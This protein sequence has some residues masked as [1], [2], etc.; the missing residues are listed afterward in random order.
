MNKR[1]IASV[2][3]EETRV[4]LLE[5]DELME[6]SVERSESGHLV[7]NIYK[8]RVKN[9]LPGMQAAF[10]DIGRDKNA[11]LYMGDAGR[12]A[13]SQHLTI[14]QDV[15]VQI[16]KDPMG[17]KGPRATI[18]LTLPGRYIVLM[19]S[20][21]YIGISRRIESEPERERLRQIAEKIRPEGMGVI[22]R[23]VA[24]DKSQDDLMKDMAYLASMW[25][26]L[27]ARAKRSN[28]PALIYKDADLVVRIVRDYFTSDVN[29]FVIDSQE[30]YNRV[31]DLL[32]YISPELIDSVTLYEPTAKDSDIFRW[33]N[34]ED[35]LES[36]RER[37][38]ELK[39]GGY[40]VID[41][42]EAMT[43]IDVNTGKFVGNTNL[44]ET[45]FQTNWE[46]IAE[47][48]RQLRLRDIG[49]IIIIDFID[50]DK[51]QQRSAVLSGLELELKKD[52]TK[53]NVL[54]ITSLG[55]VEMTRKK[56]RQNLTNMLYSPCPHCRGKGRI[57]S[58]ETVAIDIKRELR[59][60]N[61]RSRS[62]GRL[63]LQVHPQVADY[64][65]RQ[66]ELKCLERETAR[67]IVVEAVAN[68]SPERFSLLWKPD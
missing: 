36:L 49:G 59:K 27:S 25:S 22:V 60:L 30:A 38:V 13:A 46:A 53:T 9:V 8:G 28:A 51:A 20:V 54:G 66:E 33:F 34:L 1:I 42:T 23:T 68:I 67:T 17:D 55:L 16:A 52:R 50:M 3:P 47:I 40:I 19:P 41:Y 61:K 15:L 11:F 21:D 14:G 10:V 32:Q 62:G 48:A 26:A 58:P 12:Q 39:C 6:I 37:R 65:S 64:L 63:L 5:D 35:S 24:Q 2:M 18:S 29:E 4:A 44:S 43:V 45:V 7:G 31:V 57:K 56:A